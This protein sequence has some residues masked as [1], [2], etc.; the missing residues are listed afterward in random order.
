MPKRSGGGVQSIVAAE[1]FALHHHPTTTIISSTPLI[2]LDIRT[3]VKWLCS[4][5]ITHLSI[6]KCL[7]SSTAIGGNPRPTATCSKEAPPAPQRGTATTLLSSQ[8]PTT[9]LRI[10][11]LTITRETTMPKVTLM[12]SDLHLRMCTPRPTFNNTV[13]R[14]DIFPSPSGSKKN[15]TT[16]TAAPTDLRLPMS[17]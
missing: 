15:I 5:M 4:T 12:F 16:N 9:M 17:G 10:T 14:M 2:K 7:D 8:T 13:I 6:C 11:L 3:T 1:T